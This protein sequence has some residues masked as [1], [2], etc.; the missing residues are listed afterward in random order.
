MMHEYMIVAW[1]PKVTRYQAR[2]MPRVFWTQCYSFQ[3]HEAELTVKE[4]RTQCESDEDK[5]HVASSKGMRSLL[6]F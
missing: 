1:L 4:Q 5:H 6:G 3:K 2:K